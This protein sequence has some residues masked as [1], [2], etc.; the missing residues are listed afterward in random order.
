LGS[1]GWIRFIR[2][3]AFCRLW[4]NISYVKSSICKLRQ[5]VFSNL[6]L[7]DVMN[8]YSNWLK[9]KPNWKNSKRKL[10]LAR[11]STILCYSTKICSKSDKSQVTHTSMNW[12][13]KSKKNEHKLLN[14]L[15]IGKISRIE[16]IT[17]MSN[18][19]SFLSANNWWD[20][21]WWIGNHNLILPVTNKKIYNNQAQVSLIR[22]WI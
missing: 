19:K 6:T 1:H 4:S 22:W 11:M 14:K 12:N 8:P 2:I 17:L 10:S 5:K 21:V 9:L 18:N 15:R 13:K 20:L 3:V 16:P 7:L